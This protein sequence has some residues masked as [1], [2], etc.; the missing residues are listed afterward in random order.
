MN[1]IANKIVVKVSDAKISN[2]PDDTLITYSLGS[3]IGLCLYDEIHKV[4]CLFHYQLPCAKSSPEKAAVNP[5]MFADSGLKLILNKMAE[6]GAKKQHL[7]A[8][9][10]GGAAINIAPKGF[11]IGKRNHLAIRKMMWKL[12]IPIKKEDV[13]G[14]IPRTVSMD[15]SNGQ[16]TIKKSG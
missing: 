3:C 10:A 2:N 16:V 1:A 14:N 7:I 8:T 13:G 11:D 4:G 9:V 12:G 6:L 5:F 15:M